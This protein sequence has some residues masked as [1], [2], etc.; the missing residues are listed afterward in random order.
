[1]KRFHVHVNVTDLEAS[2]GFYSTLFGG[3]PSVRKPDYATWML[4]DRR[5]N[6]AISKPTHAAGVDPLRAMRAE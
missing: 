4:D 1:M 3:A 2:I 5:V 6:F